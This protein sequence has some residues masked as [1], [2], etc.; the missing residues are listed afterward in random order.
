MKYSKSIN[1]IFDF[2]EIFIPI[3]IFAVLLLTY[4]ILIAYRYLFH[5]SFAWMYELNVIAFT[6]CSIF[7]ISQSTRTDEHVIF[8]FLYD[9][10]SEN[11]KLVF[12]IIGRLVIIVMFMILLPDAYK[13]VLFMNYKTTP[14]MHIS[15]SIVYAPFIIF[16]LL[17]LIHSAVLL[18]K[19]IKLGIKILKGNNKV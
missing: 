3:I 12:R 7:A 2:F 17:T 15:F 19:E 8:P 6:W 4:I 9:K 10:L 1:R 13:T 11:K 14:I 18:V 5:A 16:V